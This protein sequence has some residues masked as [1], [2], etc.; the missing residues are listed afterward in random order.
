MSD[1]WI[2]PFCVWVAAFKI[3][4]QVCLCTCTLLGFPDGNWNLNF[5]PLEDLL[6]S[7]TLLF[8]LMSAPFQCLKITFSVSIKL[9][10]KE[11][12][13]SHLYGYIQIRFVC[14]PGFNLVRCPI[15][16]RTKQAFQK[17]AGLCY[18]KEKL[19]YTRGRSR[20]NIT[21]P[22]TAHSVSATTFTQLRSQLHRSHNQIDS[23]Q[24]VMFPHFTLWTRS[25]TT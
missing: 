4:I 20:I 23:W 25:L 10:R 8:L 11:N 9:K 13:G 3:F 6:Q 14:H 21:S 18:R 5:Y 17:E 15:F 1:K 19:L 16:K 7:E 12:H 24:S 2:E 22:L